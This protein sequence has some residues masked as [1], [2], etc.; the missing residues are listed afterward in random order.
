[1]QARFVTAVEHNSLT[2]YSFFCQLNAQEDYFTHSET[3][4]LNENFPFWRNW[5]NFYYGNN[6]LIDCLLKKNIELLHQ[7]I[8][9][10]ICLLG[11]LQDVRAKSRKSQHEARIS[12]PGSPNR[13]FLQMLRCYRWFWNLDI[14]AL[15]FALTDLTGIYGTRRAKLCHVKTSQ[16][17]CSQVTNLSEASGST[18]LYC[19]KRSM[20]WTNYQMQLQLRSI[21]WG[22][23][24]FLHE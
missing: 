8:L 15:Q 13:I 20:A 1:M 19:N 4:I 9:E 16:V 17:L 11:I 23:H 6:V 14:L 18:E 12:F 21:M 22:L 3:A 7:K 5:V 24:S 2:F 10:T